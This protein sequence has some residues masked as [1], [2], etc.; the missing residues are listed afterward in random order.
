MVLALIVSALA[1]VISLG[2]IVKAIDRNTSALRG[3]DEDGDGDDG[4]DEGGGL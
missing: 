1:I 3:E 4:E 2:S